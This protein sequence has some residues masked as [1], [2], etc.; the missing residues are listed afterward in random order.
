VSD[1]VE[2]IGFDFVS[3]RSWPSGTRGRWHVGRGGFLRRRASF[4][5]AGFDVIGVFMKTGMKKTRTA[6]QRRNGL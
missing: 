2:D 3:W 4:K 1:A 6:L 5:G